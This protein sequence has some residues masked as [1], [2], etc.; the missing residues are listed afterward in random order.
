LH[1]P[2]YCLEFF[3]ALNITLGS[4]ADVA[5]TATPII[6]TTPTSITVSSGSEPHDVPLGSVVAVISEARAYTRPLF[7]S[8]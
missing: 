8:T 2:P 7:S 4:L 6:V 3:D 1:N 5:A